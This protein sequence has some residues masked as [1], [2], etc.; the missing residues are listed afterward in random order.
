MKKMLSL[1]LA[2]CMLMCLSACENQEKKIKENIVGI[3]EWN[4]SSNDTEWIVFYGDGTGKWLADHS[5]Q[6]TYQVENDT[7]TIRS[8]TSVKTLETVRMNTKDYTKSF[9]CT[10]DGQH[11]TWI[12]APKRVYE[13]LDW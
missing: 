2:F 5:F 3:W 8:K 6:F 12:D 4:K 1:L 7:I 13:T 11:I 9:T 10:L